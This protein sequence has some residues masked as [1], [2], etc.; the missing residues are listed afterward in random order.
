MKVQYHVTD[1]ATGIPVA[2]EIREATPFD[3]KKT[4]EE[5]W[6]ELVVRFH[7]SGFIREICA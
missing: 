2:A 3:Y 4:V 7:S 1:A 6:H 5:Q